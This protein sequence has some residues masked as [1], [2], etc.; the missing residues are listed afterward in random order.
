MAYNNSLLVRLSTLDETHLFTL[1]NPLN[2][3]DENSRLIE[4]QETLRNIDNSIRVRN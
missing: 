1:F 4:H 2:F 3:D